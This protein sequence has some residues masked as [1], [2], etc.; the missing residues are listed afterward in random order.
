MPDLDMWCR[1]LKAAFTLSR[2]VNDIILMIKRSVDDLKW[3]LHAVFVCQGS[4]YEM[5]HNFFFYSQLCCARFPDY[6]SLQR[7]YV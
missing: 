3:Y 7:H 4:D 6:C 1:N 2:C 5:V